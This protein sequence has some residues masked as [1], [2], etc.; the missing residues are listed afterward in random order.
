MKPIAFYAPSDEKTGYSVAAMAFARELSKFTDIRVIPKRKDRILS[1]RWLMDL[2][3]KKPKPGEIKFFMDLPTKIADVYYTMF[4]MDM[5][6]HEWKYC[7][8][9]ANIIF[10]PSEYSRKSLESVVRKEIP[11]NVIHL[12]ISSEMK[13]DGKKLKLRDKG[14]GSYV[15]NAF[16]FLYVFEWVERKR[17]VDLI[18]AFNE[19]FHDEREDVVL[20]L[21]TYPT[22][23]PIRK[24]IKCYNSTA[25]IYL[26]SEWV[27][28]IDEL[29]RTADCYVSSSACEAW[30]EPL[31]E[32]MACGKP[33]IAGLTGNSEFMD[34]T[35]SFPV[36]DNGWEYIERNSMEGVVKPWFRYRPVNIVMLREQMRYVFDNQEEARKKGEKAAKDMEKF[37]WEASA[38]KMVEYMEV[39]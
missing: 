5:S 22:F 27:K 7:L 1:D 4:E 2:M 28:N 19:E 15:Q 35:N 23:F 32:A 6:P 38:K 20:I 30:G 34:D 26:M 14:G 25:R 29:Y 18:K 13:P 10:T 12:G 17:P 8:D 21:K 3:I 9:K 16:K 39:L 31:S 36:I 33:V 11:I 37:T 24:M